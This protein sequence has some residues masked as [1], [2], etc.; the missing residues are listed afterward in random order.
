MRVGEL[1]VMEGGG[2]RGIV[3]GERGRVIGDGSSGNGVGNQSRGKGLYVTDGEGGGAGEYAGG[4]KC[5][6]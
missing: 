6:I 2:C 4:V 1:Y 3:Q 5:D